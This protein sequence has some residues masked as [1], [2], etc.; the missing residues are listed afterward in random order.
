MALTCDMA[1]F[2]WFLFNVYY[3]MKYCK[4]KEIKMCPHAKQIHEHNARIGQELILISIGTQIR[5][6]YTRQQQH[7]YQQ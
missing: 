2:E 3:S 7:Q 4:K 6:L 1:V 5:S